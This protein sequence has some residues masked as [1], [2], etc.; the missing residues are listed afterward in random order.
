MTRSAQYHR[1]L[2]EERCRKSAQFER[3]RIGLTD[4]ELFRLWWKDHPYAKN[5]YCFEEKVFDWD[6]KTMAGNEKEAPPARDVIGDYE[7]IFVKWSNKKKTVSRDS[8][9]KLRISHKLTANDNSDPDYKDLKGSFAIH[10][11]GEACC[12]F[13]YDHANPYGQEFCFEYKPEY[14]LSMDIDGTYKKIFH[15]S[16]QPYRQPWGKVSLRWFSKRTVLPWNPLEMQEN[17]SNL[18]HQRY[19]KRLAQMIQDRIIATP[20]HFEHSWLH[21]H[22]SLPLDIVAK[23]HDFTAFLPI[24]T[25]GVVVEPNNLLIDLKYESIGSIGWV[26]TRVCA[27]A[28]KKAFQ[29]NETLANR[30]TDSTEWE[31]EQSRYQESQRRYV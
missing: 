24:K 30:V 28:R 14:Q 3:E 15:G 21:T 22:K 10:E 13:E 25:E 11:G 29:P 19:S 18:D 4:D 20:K 8:Y 26:S 23:I 16:F 5:N 9:G 31:E 27:I 6:D 17:Y 2:H 7:I 12:N 1:K